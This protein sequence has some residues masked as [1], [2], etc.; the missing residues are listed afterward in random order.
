MLFVPEKYVLSLYKLKY[1]KA[2]NVTKET[3]IYRIIFNKL[4]KG[5]TNFMVLTLKVKLNA[6]KIAIIIHNESPIN[7]TIFLLEYLL[8]KYLIKKTSNITFNP[9]TFI[10]IFY[11][12]SDINNL[13]FWQ[14]RI[15]W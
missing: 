12:L 4:E 8:K 7:K 6:I 10:I 2:N 3:D 14:F 11:T 1:L 15:H 13:L 9:L 5:L